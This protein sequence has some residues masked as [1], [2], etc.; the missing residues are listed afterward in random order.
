MHKC[1]A[2]CRK[3]EGGYIIPSFFL[4][5]NITPY[6]MKLINA[7]TGVFA[8]V[9]TIL[10][11]KNVATIIALIVETVRNIPPECWSYNYLHR[12]RPNTQH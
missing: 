7:I 9:T 4:H 2:L 8:S 3:G 5:F 11:K 10:E 6:S 12:I 1:D